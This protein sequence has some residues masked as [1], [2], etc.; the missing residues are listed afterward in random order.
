MNAQASLQ[1]HRKLSRR[2]AV[3][4]LAAGMFALGCAPSKATDWPTR[5]VTM[6][7]PF[8]PGGFTDMMARMLADSLS[9]KL[10]Q[11]FVVDNRPGAGGALAA[12]QVA[13]AKPDGYTLMFGSAG[14][15]VVVPM[16]QKVSY[17]PE[18]Q[19]QPLGIFGTG[20]MVLGVRPDLPVG[21]LQELIA[22]ARANP[23]K[24]NVASGGPGTLGNLTAALL[25]KRAGI[26]ITMVP[27]KGGGQNIGAL[28][29]GE[30]DMYFGNASELVQQKSKVKLLAVSTLK[31]IPS[32]SDVPPVA[33]LYPGFQTSAWNGLIAPAGLPPDVAARI[34]A[35]A[36]EA[37]LEPATIERLTTLGIEPSGATAAEHAAVLAEE[38]LTLKEAIEAAGLMTEQ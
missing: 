9:R 15:L 33:T 27:Y 6:V 20:P 10:G 23:G 25:A 14:Q 18:K 32:I 11:T 3:A 21:N 35:V 8:P 22:Y 24:L 36:R 5:P 28:L 37:A 29:S 1:N 30:A 26:D 4:L 7:V 31:P 34:S 38:R 19:L 2:T 17:D 16:L 13:R 12:A